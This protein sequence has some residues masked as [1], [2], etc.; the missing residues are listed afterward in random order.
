MNDLVV[1][2]REKSPALQAGSERPTYVLPGGGKRIRFTRDGR[3]V[4]IGGESLRNALGAR[5]IRKPYVAGSPIMNGAEIV[6]YFSD[7]VPE[8]VARGG[9]DLGPLAVI[10]GEEPVVTVHGK[11]VQEQQDEA[12]RAEQQRIADEK[13][14]GYFSGVVGPAR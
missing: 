8:W 11:S 3:E 2:G 5:R 9:V 14:A 6:V 12:N 1:I 13:N 4:V 7:K 10:V